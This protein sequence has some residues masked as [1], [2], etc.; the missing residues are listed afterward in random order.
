MEMKPLVTKPPPPI[1]KSPPTMLTGEAI[2]I[3]VIVAAGTDVIK[4]DCATLVCG[5][6]LNGVGVALPA[7][8]TVVTENVPMVPPAFSVAEVVVRFELD[9]CSCTMMD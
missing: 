9:D 1:E 7:T 6:K 4:V 5:V 2:L 8:A 3:P